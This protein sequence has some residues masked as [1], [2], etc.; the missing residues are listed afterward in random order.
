MEQTQR[1]SDALRAA[2]FTD[3]RCI[4]CLV[5]FY[6]VRTEYYS[7]PAL[8]EAVDEQLP[9]DRSDEKNELDDMQASAAKNDDM[10][11][12]PDGCSKEQVSKQVGNDAE[13]ADRVDVKKDAQN[14]EEGRGV[15]R[16]RGKACANKQYV[17][18]VSDSSEAGMKR[19]VPIPRLVT[20]GHTGYLLFG[21][22]PVLAADQRISAAEAG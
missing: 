5:K 16:R 3:I 13:D 7:T 15:K 18:W 2:S 8:A 12:E 1:T 11:K 4:E 9:G 17:P 21:R 22:K 14:A 6:D 10:Q 19:L 20:K